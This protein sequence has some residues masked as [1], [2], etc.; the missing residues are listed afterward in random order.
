M[1]NTAI[2]TTKNIPSTT[3]NQIPETT[4]QTSSEIKK[5]SII[6]PSSNTI[7]ITPTIL[8]PTS[9]PTIPKTSN[10]PHTIIPSTTHTIPKPPS[11]TTITTILTQNT[12]RSEPIISTTIPSIIPKTHLNT[13]VPYI[14]NST[15][16]ISSTI[17]EEIP[18]TSQLNNTVN[19]DYFPKK[20]NGGVKAGHVVAIVAA[21][22]FGVWSSIAVYCIF[23][24]KGV[25]SQVS[26]E[27]T[28]AALKSLEIS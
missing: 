12:Q 24:Y 9:I 18:T 15:I 23:F 4:V 5:S 16:P 28:I 22:I 17:M 25:K 26:S 6:I 20:E 27:S 7:N 2:P 19:N 3:I 10:I 21:C 14:P 13:S 1:P 11:P 8:T